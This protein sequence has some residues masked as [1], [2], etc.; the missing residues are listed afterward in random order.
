[1]ADDDTGPYWGTGNVK[2]KPGT[3]GPETTWRDVGRGLRYGTSK[4]IIGGIGGTP[5][6]IEHLLRFGAQYANPFT[7]KPPLFSQQQVK[8]WTQT[9]EQ[10]AK[11]PPPPPSPLY[12]QWAKTG[13][14]TRFPQPDKI[15]SWLPWE[16]PKD[17]SPGYV[18]AGE[19]AGAL[20]PPTA[21]LGGAA[22]LASPLAEAIGNA[23]VRAATGVPTATARQ[24]L[25]EAAGW[26]ELSMD[27][28][29]KVVQDAVADKVGAATER[30]LGPMNPMGEA[31]PMSTPRPSSLPRSGA[32]SPVLSKLAPD[33]DRDT[34]G[35]P[36]MTQ[37]G[38]DPAWNPASASPGQVMR[39]KEGRG[40]LQVSTRVPTSVGGQ[41]PNL[42]QLNVDVASMS[43]GH[44]AAAAK[45][46]SQYENMRPMPGASDDEIIEQFK[47][48][49]K[50][51]LQALWDATPEDVRNRAMHWYD[52]V[53]S[54]SG[55][56]AAQHEIPHQATAG[57]T[58][59]LSPGKDFYQ[60]ASMTERVADIMHDH[61]N[62]PWSPEMD[63]VA[64]NIWTKKPIY[65]D[66]LN[67][68]R[69]K[70]LA[71]MP[72][73]YMRGMWIRTFDEA[74]NPQQYR[75]MNP[76]GDFGDLARN[77]DGTP[78][79]LAWQTPDNMANAVSMYRDPSL[80]NI[81]DHLGDA[82]KVRNFY[83]DI[84]DPSNPDHITVDTHAVG[85]ANFRPVAA[86]QL[87]AAH[88]FGGSEKGITGAGSST[89]SGTNGTYP[90]YADAYREGAAANGVLPLQYQAVTWE[91][92]RSMF[93]GPQKNSLMPKASA[94]WQRYRNGEIDA[95][96][97]RN[98]VAALAQPINPPWYRP[99]GGDAAP[100]FATSYEKQLPPANVGGEQGA[101]TGA[102]GATAGA[103]T[104][105]RPFGTA[106]IAGPHAPG[107]WLISPSPQLLSD[108]QRSVER[109]AINRVENDPEGMVGQYTQRWGP[110]IDADN[111]RELF[112]EYN[113][114]RALHSASV[115]EPAD[116]VARQAYEQQL[117]K[118]PT[119][120][121]TDTVLF[122]AGGA[123]AGKSSGLKNNPTLANAAQIVY[124]T[125]MNTISPALDKIDAALNAGKDV[126][127]VYTYRDPLDSFN[128]VL[129]RAARQE[130]KDGVPGR[131]VPIPGVVDTHVGANEV[132]PMLAWRYQGDPRVQ[133]H[134][135]D[136][137]RGEGNGTFVNSFSD[138]PRFPYSADELANL[139][140]QRA[141]D[142]LASGR[143]SPAVYKGITTPPVPRPAPASA[144]ARRIQGQPQPGGGGAPSVGSGPIGEATRLGGI[145]A[146]Q[147]P[148]AME[149]AAGI[150][151]PYG[152]ADDAAAA[153]INQASGG[154]E[155]N[156]NMSAA[157]LGATATP[158][159]DPTQS[160]TGALSGQPQSGPGL[161]VGAVQAAHAPLDTLMQDVERAP[162]EE[163]KDFE[164]LTE[165]G[166]DFGKDRLQDTLDYEAE[167][168]QEQQEQ[169]YQQRQL[170]QPLD[171]VFQ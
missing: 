149:E 85:A 154:S 81:S 133:F 84:I 74:H 19:I 136:N 79:T 165:H 164:W 112:P 2:A 90:V 76:E 58:A 4:G 101:D 49:N 163:N 125:H 100:S 120:N 145:L 42:N 3:Y 141:N 166:K 89:I 118:A 107:P 24:L 87:Q 78:T 73:D 38:F 21:I 135:F 67:Q 52:G 160:A 50:E 28:L 20:I 15:E 95:S 23:G 103:S 41:D 117:P 124:D 158:T 30:V 132:M 171:E 97:A 82:H 57:M 123:G 45:A 61:Q 138:L 119:G 88:N 69:G 56:L 13:E 96:Q 60:N 137:S 113:A 7:P 162:E 25:T 93:E 46:I 99:S 122:T 55:G 39:E 127:V 29:T 91:A 139:Y 66:P 161:S 134:W 6:A 128:G 34:A 68:M 167:L 26:K 131:T 148:T 115:Q 77:N 12:E 140:G 168:Q 36:A 44:K 47:N 8:G 116:W 92:I 156:P 111:A 129:D 51:N 71:E 75:V 70:T 106:N 48:N 31:W 147:K 143:I 114:N 146:G 105:R 153:A 63:A 62:T 27:D 9:P 1:M 152:L 110:H 43:P 157:A 169:Q 72:N 59:A 130:E 37:A 86:T 5:G 150:A 54:W 10:K 98:E 155:G 22:R 11:A 53:H 108:E 144:S 121:Q 170:N 104:V 151:L 17:V 159:P 40:D 32:P 83:N 80:Q 14:E 94:I 109:S 18:K 126:H 102:A 16:V 35:R 65:A 33:F 64:N 142:A